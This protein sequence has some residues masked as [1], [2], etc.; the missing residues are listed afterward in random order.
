[1][2]TIGDNDRSDTNVTLKAAQVSSA[3]LLW[4][5]REQHYFFRW[6]GDISYASY[7]ASKGDKQP[8]ARPFGG[9]TAGRDYL[10]GYDLQAL[11]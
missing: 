3:L 9:L 2:V 10:P 4:M 6:I 1:M 7:G 11:S 5:N 8:C